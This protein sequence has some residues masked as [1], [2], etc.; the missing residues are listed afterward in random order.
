MP[1]SK[2]TADT[3]QPGKLGHSHQA[4]VVSGGSTTSLG[5]G[6]SRGLEKSSLETADEHKSTVDKWPRTS[7]AAREPQRHTRDT[8]S[9]LT[10]PPQLLEGIAA[11]ITA[12]IQR[13]PAEL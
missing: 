7:F 3:G 2:S 13:F 1:P 11:T 12:A 4:A 8:D 5:I 10:F 9:R 6:R